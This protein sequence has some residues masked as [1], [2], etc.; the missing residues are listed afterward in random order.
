MT[1]SFQVSYIRGTE[2]GPVAK[3]KID[4]RWDQVS[5]IS[6]QIEEYLKDASL[7]GTVDISSPT[8]NIYVIHSSLKA[9][10]PF[11]SAVEK[12]EACVAGWRNEH[13]IAPSSQQ[14]G[15]AILG[16]A[17]LMLTGA[18]APSPML[19]DDGTVGAFWRSGQHYVSIDFEVDGI[20]TWVGTN[21]EEFKSGT[22]EPSGAL[23]AE[24]TSELKSIE[25]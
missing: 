24:L 16:V 3:S 4:Y 1:T 14:I 17:N 22:W 15:S 8:V 13:S 2:N 5:K 20:H 9:Y 10:R 21:G 7:A 12:Y 11:F 18:P 19:L 23:P 25:A 6:A